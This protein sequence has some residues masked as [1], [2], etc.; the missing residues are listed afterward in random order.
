MQTHEIKF[1]IPHA[2]LINLHK[3]L[4]EIG[5]DIKKQAAIRYY[6]KR[7][8]SLGKSAELAGMSRIEFIDFL[9]FNDEPV[10]QYSDEELDEILTDTK[11]IKAVLDE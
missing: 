8:L 5:E 3:S 1:K 10:F 2:V 9:K 6:K 11:K 7:I 4:N